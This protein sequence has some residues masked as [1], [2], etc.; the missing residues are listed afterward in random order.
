MGQLTKLTHLDISYNPSLTS[1]PVTLLNISTLKKLDC[2]GCN[3]LTS[4]PYSVCKQGIKAVRRFL[5]DLQLERGQNQKLIPITVIGKTRA[6]K[7]SLVRSLQESTRVLTNRT[8]TADKLDEATR[9]FNICEAEVNDSCKLVFIDFGGQEIYHFAYQLT[10]KA[11]SVPL[12]VIDISEFDQLL[13]ENG[14]DRAC[15]EVCMEWLSHLYLSRPSLDRPVVALTHCDT[16]LI[17]KEQLQLRKQQLVDITERLRIELITKEKNVSML[18]NPLLDMT[19]F[20]DISLPLIKLVDILEFSASSGQ[21]EIHALEQALVKAAS[22][23]VNEIPGSWYAILLDISSR[24]DEPYIKVTDIVKGIRKSR[25]RY[26]LQYIH[27]IGRIMWFQEIQI[28]SGYIFHQT[29][30]L[31]SLIGILYDHAQ[32][33]TWED[34]MH[35]FLPYKFCERQIEAREYEKM[36]NDFRKTGVIEAALLHNLLNTESSLPV[37]VAITLLKTF[38]LICGPIGTEDKQKFIVPYFSQTAITVSDDMANLIPL[39]VDLFLNGLPVPNYVYHLITAAYLD[40]HIDMFN[41][42]E[43]G[44]S[45]AH[46][47]EENRIHRYLIHN[48]RN[49]HVTLITLTSLQNIGEAWKKQ[50]D[51]LTQI[52][53]EL[54]SVWRGVRYEHVFYCS[55]CVLTKQQHPTTAVNPEWFNK[56][57]EPN[58]RSYEHLKPQQTVY[59]GLEFCTCDA[60]THPSEGGSLPKPLR[61]PCEC[62]VYINDVSI[63]LN[64]KFI[65][66]QCIFYD[67]VK[68]HI[69]SPVLGFPVSLS[70]SNFLYSHYTVDFPP[71]STLII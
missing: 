22:A 25:K 20:C 9:V 17:T 10:F 16:D 60:A 24:K 54:E 67:K 29:K 23:L 61:N 70:I 13:T 57:K 52:T 41:T 19:T 65:L 40:I 35:C 64:F 55:H 38:H 31:S 37:Q 28:L 48:V 3:A 63:S 49:K 36:V 26:T 15:Q 50:L 51:A 4:P 33:R 8:S 45:G 46:V 47:I 14:E 42:V 44:Q 5:K 43:A 32:G 2:V 71:I 34:R 1:L 53:A 68:Y 27:E 21:A 39:K 18:T 58:R 7:T 11:Q 56:T 6:G 12:L 69:D 59:T 30:I 62:A 66:L